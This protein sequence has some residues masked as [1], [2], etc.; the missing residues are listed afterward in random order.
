MTAQASSRK[1]QAA[2]EL[3]RASGITKSYFAGKRELTVL[4]G[5]DLAV[6]QGEVLIICGPS[7]AGKSTLLHILG[8]LDP[9]TE[10]DLLYRG[11]S[12]ILASP[13]RKAFIRNRKFGFV[14]QFYHLLPDLNVLENTLLP[15][16]IRESTLSWFPAKRQ[17]REKVEN[18]LISVGL[19]GR[20]KHRPSQLS[21]GERQRAA[22]ARALVTDPELLFCDEP[23]GNLDTKTAGE[24]LDVLWKAREDFGQT[25]VM[26][27]HN[28]ELARKGTRRLDMIDGK[29]YQ[30]GERELA[31]KHAN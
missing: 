5:I 6:A 31:P 8:L 18:T 30:P 28:R 15:L 17:Y 16:M 29:L 4:K 27:T 3:L 19:G 2:R 10:G 13:R 9:P 25:M 21:G 14:F 24:I 11:E 20:L 23:T 26:V 22:I 7:G 12:V 1:P